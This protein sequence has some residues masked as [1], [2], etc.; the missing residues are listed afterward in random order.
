MQSGI[1]NKTQLNIYMKVNTIP[2]PTSVAWPAYFLAWTDD[3]FVD[4]QKNQGVIFIFGM[5]MNNER[6]GIY[7][8]KEFPVFTFNWTL[9]AELCRTVYMHRHYIRHTSSSLSLLETPLSRWSG[10]LWRLVPG[11]H[12]PNQSVFITTGGNKSHVNSLGAFSKN[13]KQTP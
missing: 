3:L 2:K 1:F 12:T 10:T 13:W 4:E 9:T 5:Y 6:L 8:L 11:C 7:S